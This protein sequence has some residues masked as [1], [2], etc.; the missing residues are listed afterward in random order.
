M[1]AQA[2]WILDLGPEGGAAGGLVCATGTPEAIVQART[3][4]GLALKRELAAI[5]P[6]R[7]AR[8]TA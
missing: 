2:D 7:K 4:T 6:R 3:P 5:R 8:Q 1:L